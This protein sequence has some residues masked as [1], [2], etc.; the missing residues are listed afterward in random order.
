MH[1]RIIDSPIGPLTL[2]GEGERLLAIHLPKL[3]RAVPPPPDAALDGGALDEA[4]RQL[5]EFF[6]GRR[7]AFELDLDPRGSEF[8]RRVWFEL[9]EIGYGETISYAELARRVGRPGAARAVGAANGRNPLPIVLPCH[10]VIGSDG[11]LVGYGGGLP[12][13]R[14][15]L[16][17]EGA[18]AAKAP[19]QSR[20]SLAS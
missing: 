8:Q 16:E 1:H 2:V 13:K 5:G 12:A 20:L 14:V 10:R 3:G 11:S 17:L 18:T 15:L 9:A 19:A 7:R 4:A 6:A